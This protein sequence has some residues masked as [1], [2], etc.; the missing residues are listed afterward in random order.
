[1]MLP[2]KLGTGVSKPRAD[3]PTPNTITQ[4]DKHKPTVEQNAKVG[5]LAQEKANASKTKA[6]QAPNATPTTKLALK[7]DPQKVPVKVLETVPPHR[8]SGLPAHM[9]AHGSN[10]CMFSRFRGFR[11]GMALTVGTLDPDLSLLDIEDGLG[12]GYEV[13]PDDGDDDDNDSDSHRRSD[14]KEKDQS[15][16]LSPIISQTDKGV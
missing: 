15:R 11:R 8:P 14:L 6:S 9:E 5:N 3:D 10:R 4:S 7:A 2:R 16:G 12:E 13:L 1:L